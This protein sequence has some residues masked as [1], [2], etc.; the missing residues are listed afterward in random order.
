MNNSFVG[1][2]QN[3]LVS[4]DHDTWMQQKD[5]ESLSIYDE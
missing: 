5:E 4:S 3:K 1:T 2:R